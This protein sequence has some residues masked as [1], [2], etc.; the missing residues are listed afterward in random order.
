[1]EP[2]HTPQ[3]I[4]TLSNAAHVAEGVIIILFAAVIVA[5]GFGYL[6]KGWQRYL[7]PGIGLLASFV[8]IG[9]I[10]FDHIH[11][12]PRAW[13]WIINDMQQ[14]QHLFMGIL[15]GL[16][17]IAA[18]IGLKLQKEWLR[19]GLPL[20]IAVIG[21]LF[22]VHPQH[23]NSDEAA[24][25]LFIHRVAGTSLIIAG[26]AQASSL[27][28][29]QWRKMLAIVAGAGLLLSAVLFISYREPLMSAE[30]MMNMN[31]GQSV[32]QSE[33]TYSL[34][35]TDMAAYKTNEPAELMFDIRDENNNVLKDFDTVHE[36]Q[37]HLIVVR[38]D[39]AHFQHVHPNFDKASGMFAITG[40]KFPTDGE[41]RVFADFTASSAQ[42]GAD[43]MKL[44]ATPY[45]D[46]KVGSGTYTAQQITAD[47]LKSDADGFTTEITF[48]HSDSPGSTT[49]WAKNENTFAVDIK[50]DSQPYKNLEKYL[51]ALGHMVVLGPN[52]EFVHA[53]ALTEDV[54]QQNG[55]I[56]FK[57]NFPEP[58]MYKVYLQTQAAGKVSTFDY[59]L[60]AKEMPGTTTPS[61]QPAEDMNMDHSGH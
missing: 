51:G 8:I 5:Q 35:L 13:E 16:G 45:K 50:K 17:S 23:G 19:L 10:F 34:N 14:R 37:M 61:D 30:D 48:P 36:K 56:Y 6:Q 9:F 1:M 18:L 40:F 55:L 26:L 42:M 52:L 60:T 24:R 28:L 47:K 7:I 43:G 57:V 29:K 22:L 4:V 2:L 32:V 46:V 38:K 25:G 21:L 11:E 31:H 20:A 59:D 53:H 12:L 49:F 44:P 33:R 15:I 39:R 27:F 54:A 58:G 41:Y 3:E